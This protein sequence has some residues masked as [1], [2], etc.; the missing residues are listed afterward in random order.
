MACDD[1]CRLQV[2][3]LHNNYLTTLPE[4]LVAL[5]RMRSLAVSFN[6]FIVLPLVIAHMTHVQVSDVEVVSLAGNSIE[7]LSSE[8]LTELRYTKRLDLRLNELTL[9]TTDTLKF[10]VLERLTHL[11]VRDNRIRELDL[12]VLRSLEHLS[13]ERN[14]MVSLRLNG[15]SLRSLAAAGNRECLVRFSYNDSCVAAVFVC[16]ALSLL[17]LLLCFLCFCFCMKL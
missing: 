5:H 6:R 4:Q 1:Y 3:H 13:C 10:V 17:L 2:L 7:R 8:T 16:V 14:S 9:P 15:S 12:H 11:D